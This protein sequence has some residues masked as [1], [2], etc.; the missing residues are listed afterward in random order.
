MEICRYLI[1]MLGMVYP[2]ILVDFSSSAP[3][4]A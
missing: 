1:F 2:S 4:T 3:P